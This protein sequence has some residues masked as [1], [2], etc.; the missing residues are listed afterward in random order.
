MENHQPVKALKDRE[1]SEDAAIN[2]KLKDS[3]KGTLIANAQAGMGAAPLLWNNELTGMYIA[4]KLQN[5][6]TYKG[7]N[8]G[9][10]AGRELNSFYSG[11]ASRM[12]SSSLLNVQ[13][14]SSPSISEKRYLDNQANMVSFNNLW[15]LKTD[16]QLTANINYLNDYQQKS[17]YA[18]TENY[19]PNDETIKIEE[20]L[21]SRLRKERMGA[22]IQLN[23]NK[24]K[25]YFNNLLKF[26]GVWDRER[27]DAI[28]TDSVYQHLKKP[29]YSISNT[30]NLV[31]TNEKHTWTFYSFNGYNTSSQ[32]LRVQ[33]VLYQQ[34]F[35]P[36]PSPEAMVQE[37]SLIHI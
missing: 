29:N 37:L 5:I 7:N 20:L 34:L 9:D 33:P 14:P 24:E 3:A 36:A 35:D 27:G 32:T 11:D 16:Y 19:L 22:D 23:A 1:F 17:S 28:S 31:K 13:A 8:S 4:K 26:E 21:N 18:Y 30:F 2:L 6:T 12:K 25:Y 10:D 15:S